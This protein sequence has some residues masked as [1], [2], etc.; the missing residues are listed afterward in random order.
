MA[1]GSL[2]EL[3]PPPFVA[4]NF[5]QTK[6]SSWYQSSRPDTVGTPM[7]L[8][9]SLCSRQLMLH[10]WLTPAADFTLDPPVTHCYLQLQVGTLS[11]A[12]VNRSRWKQER[13]KAPSRA[14]GSPIHSEETCPLKQLATSHTLNAE[15][16]FSTEGS[17]QCSRQG[18]ATTGLLLAVYIHLEGIFLNQGDGVGNDG[19]V[20]KSI[21]DD[22]KQRAPKGSLQTGFMGNNMGNEGHRRQ[23]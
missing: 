16:G 6:G 5:L 23:A 22:E 18:S 15:E 13:L 11:R 1:R 10:T 4:P 7:T 21:Q 12:N 14:R 19:K 9:A 8:P 3:D 20:F 2:P 17:R